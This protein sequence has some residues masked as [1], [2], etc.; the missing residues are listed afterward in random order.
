MKFITS[1]RNSY[2]DAFFA[3]RCPSVLTETICSRLR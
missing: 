3:K 1:R 2:H